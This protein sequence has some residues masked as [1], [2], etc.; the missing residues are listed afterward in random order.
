MTLYIIY[1]S[2]FED[3]LVHSK[4]S[5]YADDSGTGVKGDSIAEIIPKL[6]EDGENVLKYMA[7]NGLVANP[8][9]TA[10]LF[11]NSKEK[12]DPVE[13]PIGSALVIQ[14]KNAKLLGM[15]LDDSQT[16]STHFYSKG[17]VFSALNQ[18]LFILRRM[19]NHLLPAGLRKVAESLFN[20]KIRYGLQMCGK[21]RWKVSD[22]TPKLMKDL[23]VSQNKMLR[24][25]NNSRISDK[26]STASLLAKFNMMSV[27]QINAQM[28]LSEMWKAVR[29]E[30]HPFNLEKRATG[31]DVRSM[32][33]ISNEMLPVKSFS[34]QH[35]H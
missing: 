31:P 14:E 11:L 18:R 1:V 24:L 19:K 26:I 13:I 5:T 4:A 17:G 25:L 15:T 8:S 20:S 22:P 9:K 2:D 7:S 12:C 16:W 29:D 3:W 28:K 30:D 33:S 6:E 10:L 21:I 34:E 32:R 23:Q 35:F 27:N